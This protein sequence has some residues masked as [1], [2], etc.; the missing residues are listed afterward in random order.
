MKQKTALD[1][2]KLGHNAKNLKGR[3][4]FCGTRPLSFVLQ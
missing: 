1:I 2:L 4:P 3:I